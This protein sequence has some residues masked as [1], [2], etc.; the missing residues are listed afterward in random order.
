MTIGIEASHANKDKRTGVDEYSWQIIN[1]LKKIIPAEV[2]VILYS[3]TPL[4]GELADLPPN[5]QSRVLPWPWKLWSQICLSHELWR[6]MPDV[7]FAPGQLV[8]AITPK[9]TVT[10]VHDSAFKVYPKAYRFF[11]RLYL[12]LMNKM[13]LRKSRIIL[14]PSDFS[15]RELKR[16]YDFDTNRVSVTPL[17]YNRAIYRKIQINFEE[18]NK[19]LKNIGITK[20]FFIFVGRLE[21]K[22][23]VANIVRAFDVIKKQYD[24]ALVMV[25]TPGCGYKEV[26]KTIEESQNKSD[27]ILTG[28][29]DSET[30]AKL[31]NLA[32]AMIFTTNYEGFG[33][34]ALEAM[35]SCCPVVVSKG[36]SLEEVVG[37]AALV[38]DPK[39]PDDIASAA[40]LLIS[41][42]DLRNSKI[43]A[44]MARTEL[45]SWENTAKL[46]WQAL[47][48]AGI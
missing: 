15:R 32:E 14:T 7:F 24:C 41:N 27:I 36:N 38:A 26:E 12:C 23:N 34:P 30:V 10:T 19:V 13:V 44:G 2:R 46:T 29:L 22:K 5:W 16:L 9:N 45:F 39:S 4:I 17:G 47:R 48:E 6:N 20:P 42:R 37:D 31:Y 1:H 40:L 43:L 3:Q 8:P 28:W 25:G 21:Q 35:A 18:K 33:L 11:S